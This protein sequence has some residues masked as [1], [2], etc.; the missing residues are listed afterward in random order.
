VDNKRLYGQVIVK[1]SIQYFWDGCSVNT[2]LSPILLT[3]FPIFPRFPLPYFPF[4]C[5][6][7]NDLV[8]SQL[9]HGLYLPLLFTD[10]FFI[11]PR[12]RVCY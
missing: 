5:K 9:S 3:I 6:L 12:F 8:K 11:K 7:D 1:V 4:L 10:L 2:D